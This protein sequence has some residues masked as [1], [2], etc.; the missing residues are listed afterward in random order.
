MS[1]QYGK[2]NPDVFTKEA[3]FSQWITRVIA[4]YAG[5]EGYNIQINVVTKTA[6]PTSRD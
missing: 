1:L 4:P 6:R 3:E 2:F 5:I